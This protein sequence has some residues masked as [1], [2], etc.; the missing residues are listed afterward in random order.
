MQPRGNPPVN[1]SNALIPVGT[2]KGATASLKRKGEMTRPANADSTCSRKE[3]ADQVKKHFQG[4]VGGK[5]TIFAFYSPTSFI[6]KFMVLVKTF[7][8]ANPKSGKRRM[9]PAS[10]PC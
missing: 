3:E 4:E 2:T 8:G 5:G 10:R 1:S 7:A 6:R 9:G